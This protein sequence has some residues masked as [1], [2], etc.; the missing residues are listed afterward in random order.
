MTPF[1]LIAIGI[2]VYLKM[3]T[4]RGILQ[5]QLTFK[6]LAFSYLL[7]MVGR[8]FI[9]FV[10]IVLVLYFAAGWTT[11]AVAL[12]FLASFRSCFLGE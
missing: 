8:L 4:N 10:L 9:T 3:S 5:G 6:K 12:G 7:E 1:L 11:E 2:P